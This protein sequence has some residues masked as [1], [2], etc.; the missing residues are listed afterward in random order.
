MTI[1]ENNFP[2]EML[3]M[4]KNVV[5]VKRLS[6]T[7]FDAIAYDIR[8]RHM[9][10]NYNV[11]PW[12]QYLP[13]IVCAAKIAKKPFE[14]SVSVPFLSEAQS[15]QSSRFARGICRVFNAGSCSRNPSN[16]K[17]VCSKC[18]ANGHNAN[19]CNK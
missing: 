12:G 19:Q 9:K 6:T 5:T 17:H 7:G 8:F 13:E 1:R 14:K 16:F 11:L 18:Q 10:A 2:D 15:N 4:I 3:G